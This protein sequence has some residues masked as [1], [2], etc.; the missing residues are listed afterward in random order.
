MIRTRYYVGLSTSDGLEVS[1]EI[2][3][4]VTRTVADAYGGGCTCYHAIGYWQGTREGSLILE[5]LSEDTPERP[6]PEVLA[7][8][9]AQLAEQSSVL[10]TA[11]RVA[12]G[13]VNA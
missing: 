10:W 12:G 1:R 9:L 2:Q 13:F 6:I 8:V 5:A 11:E 7:A 3:D 4:K